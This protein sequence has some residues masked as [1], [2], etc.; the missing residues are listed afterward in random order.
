MATLEKIRNQGG[1]LVTIII[2]LALLAFILGDI[3]NSAGTSRL[4]NDLTVAEVFND[5][6]NVQDYQNRLNEVFDV[7]RQNRGEIDEETSDQL[8]NQTW[9]DFIREAVL[10]PAYEAYGISVT[11][12]EM[13]EMVQGE[14]LHPIIV[15]VFGDPNTGEVNKDGIRNFIANIN[16]EFAQQK[17]FWLYIEK[18]IYS[19]RKITKYNNLV[20]KAIYTPSLQAQLALQAKSSNAN[21]EFVVKNKAEVADSLVTYTDAEVK[22]YYEKNKAK[23]NQ[24]SQIRDILYVTYDVIPSAQD[25]QDALLWINGIVNEFAQST[26]DASFVSLNGDD[27]FNDQYFGKGQLDMRLDT[28]MFDQEVGYL[29]GPYFENMTYKLAKLSKIEQR[30]DSVKASHILIRNENNDPAVA[31]KAA[32]SL[33]SLKRMVESGA[34]FADLARTNSQDGSAQAGGDLGWFTETMMVKPFS[35][36]CF[37]GKKGDLVIVQTQF[38]HHLIQI[39]ELSKLS[40][41]VQVAILTRKVEASTQTYQD[42]YAK[43]STFSAENREIASF[44]NAVSTQSLVP[45]TATV[46]E[47]DR[48]ISGLEQPRELIKWA[49]TAEKGQVSEVFEFGNRFV[50]ATLANIKESGTQPLEDV[51][52]QVQAAVLSEKK[53]QYLLEKINSA[54]S[55]GTT[56]E[57]LQSAIN[58]KRDV[59]QGINFESFQIPGYGA[60]HEVIAHINHLKEGEISKPI[61]GQNAVFVVKITA[62]IANP[63]GDL[64][65]EQKRINAMQIGSSEMSSYNALKKLADIQDHR[66]KWF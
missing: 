49:F 44:N 29:V 38:G 66:S 48:K 17:P 19:K 21:V 63:A 5:E 22:A 26:N 3:L 16:G 15:Q 60:E 40:K 32:Q 9:E 58:G 57:G 54:L 20:K 52:T 30:A 43:A 41:K 62:R 31:S 2:G 11:L 51:K 33:D 56:F 28:A 59:A 47:N 53:G 18:E 10:N 6:L 13:K 46:M 35:E 55:A 14:N 36:A 65:A 61:V 25:N 7:Y 50:V 24:E 42:I 34:S 1:L 4:S 37:S 23:F 64:T 12:E 27:S 45:R 39:N 8:T